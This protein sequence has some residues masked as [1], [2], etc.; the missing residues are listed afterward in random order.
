MTH[1][2]VIQFAKVAGVT[3]QAIYIALRRGDLRKDEQTKKINPKDP[4]SEEYL[5]NNTTQRAQGQMRKMGMYD[6]GGAGDGDIFDDSD[7]LVGMSKQSLEKRKLREGIMLAQ[8]KRETLRGTLV[9]IDTMREAFMKFYAVLTGELHPLGDKIS[10]N[11]AAVYGV[12]DEKASAKAREIVDNDVFK[13][14]AHMKR[15]ME[16]FSKQKMDDTS[17]E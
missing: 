14:L 7:D 12:D 3:R 11:L 16:D 9:N 1:L 15:L 13:S 17:E 2:T 10:Q 6:D 4:F 5:R 8:I